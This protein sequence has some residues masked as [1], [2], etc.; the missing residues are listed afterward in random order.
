M[1]AISKQQL[2]QEIDRL[3]SQYLE[4]AYKI[5]RQFPQDT[6]TNTEKISLRGSVLRYVDPTEPVA[7]N[8]WD[9]LK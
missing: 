3:D 7:L 5:L 9:A 4:L 6:H 1:T 8:D 2:K